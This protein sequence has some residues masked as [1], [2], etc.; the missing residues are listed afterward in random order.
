MERNILMSESMFEQIARKKYWYKFR[1]FILTI[2]TFSM[3]AVI[4]VVSEEENDVWRKAS[5]IFP[6]VIVAI[7][8]YLFQQ[9]RYYRL[10]HR[11]FNNTVYVAHP[12]RRRV[13]NPDRK[14]LITYQ[15]R[16]IYRKQ[17][18]PNYEGEIVLDLFNLKYGKGFHHINIRPSEDDNLNAATSH[19][20]T[21]DQF[22]FSQFITG[23]E[24]I[25]VEHP[26]IKPDENL[27]Q[28][29]S[30]S[31]YGSI[32]YQASIWKREQEKGGS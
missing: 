4:L 28:N 20:D 25:Y 14:E 22:G 29:D 27:E 10:V 19:Y 9:F 24:K 15:N 13:K 11:I 21:E 5:R 30:K 32:L 18:E 2:I 17:D 23:K 3:I 1:I 7:S 16:I 8:L 31:A 6:P 12:K 26:Y